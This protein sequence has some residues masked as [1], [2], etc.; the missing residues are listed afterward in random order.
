MP[1]PTL[2]TRLRE[3]WERAT[4]DA[5][6][7]QLPL[8]VLLGVLCVAAAV[9]LAAH[10]DLPWKLWSGDACEYAEMARRLA[11]G[12]GFTTGVIY[13]AELGFGASARHPAVMRP[14][15][16]PLALAPVF[17][18]TDA[19]DAAA[20]ALTGAF[21]LGTVA[22]TA[23]L[24]AA[25]AG[26]VSG[27]VAA[28]ALAATPAFA[29]LAQDA[30]SETPF[31]FFVTLAFLLLVRQRSAFGV[32]L[33][34]G[35]AYLT[36][37]NGLLLLPVLMALLWLRRPRALRPLLLCGAGFA[38]VALPWWLRNLWVA[39]NPFFSLLN[40]NLYFSP[41]V[42]AMHDSLYYVLQPDP[43]SPVAMHPFSKL[44]IQLPELIASWPLAS[45]NLFACIGV[46][47]ACARGHPASLGF[48]ALAIGTTVAVA[49]GLPQG[50]YFVP[51]L[52]T[53]I[54]LGASGW[55]R[56][57]GRL[58]LAGLT[59][60]LLAPLLPSFPEPR[61]D[62]GMVRGFF[63]AER[64]ALR[65]DP[66]RYRREDAGFEAMRR[67]L[68]DR[69]LVLAQGA[70]R[71]A[72]ET[73]AIAIYATNHAEDFRRIVDEVPVEW[74]QIER[75]RKVD[76]DE[77]ERHFERREDCGPGLYRRRPASPE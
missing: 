77:F 3:R 40:L 27:A 29:G 25:V 36:R 76:R 19:H 18:L 63:D 13:P 60:L 28:L 44:R 57:G 24:G 49:F 47:L 68:A 17:A 62:L 43:T 65:E 35:L 22:L 15:L 9:W 74:A 2:I 48:A 8:P 50:R 4:S 66:A 10:R 72:W 11:G 32:G 6:A 71:I 1:E 26:P 75:W 53:L 12:E 70:A 7:G 56:H 64:R 58:A 59:L 21:F 37:Y 33:A 41:H 52:P 30:V 14:P 73:G 20:H 67:C 34:C 5:S 39:G 46:L 16:W 61:D 38:L 23:A 69:P 54:A 42:A 55:I 45:L 31:A 51:L